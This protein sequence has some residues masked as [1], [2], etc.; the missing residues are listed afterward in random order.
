MATLKLR[1]ESAALEWRC[2]PLNLNWQR[3]VETTKANANV[4]VAHRK[5]LQDLNSN[6]NLASGA[7]ARAGCCGVSWL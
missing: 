1:G 2:A 4:P 3:E 7:A 5:G 6:Q